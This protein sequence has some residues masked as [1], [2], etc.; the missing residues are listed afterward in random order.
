MVQSLKRTKGPNS[1]NPDMAVAQEHYSQFQQHLKV[2]LD[3][4]NKII[5]CLQPIVKY[6]TEISNLTEKTY[7]TLPPEDRP[8]AERLSDLVG[9]LNAFV[10]ET[11]LPHSDDDVINP[12]KGTFKS[13]DDLG[14][15]NNDHHSAFLILESN[16]AKLEAIQKEPDKNAKEIQSYTEKIESRTIEVKR[17]EE[18]F[19]SRMSAIWENRFQLVG[20]PLS[21]LLEMIT[22]LGTALIKR[23]EPIAA[24]LGPELLA[25]DYPAV[26]PPTPKK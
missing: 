14:S 22:G 12:L 9:D 19:I 2:F 16:H 1:I 20:R 18:E 8:L 6:A 4:A 25:Q 5:A 10:N 26:D 21:S 17:L 7:D 24:V 23:V 3:D 13:V 11:I 15:I